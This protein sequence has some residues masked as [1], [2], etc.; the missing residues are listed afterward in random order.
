MPIRNRSLSVPG[1]SGTHTWNGTTTSKSSHGL[2][3]T[4]QDTVGNPLGE[5]PL[6]A[7]KTETIGGAINGRYHYLVP[8]VYDNY[9]AAVVQSYG[10]SHLTVPNKFIPAATALAA[11]HPGEPMVDIPVF[12]LELKDLPSMYKHAFRRAKSLANAAKS[13]DLASVK[14]YLKDPRNPAEDWLN[15]HFGWAPLLSDL[16]ALASLGSDMQKRALMFKNASNNR[17]TRRNKLGTQT[18]ISVNNQVA[19]DTSMASWY[20]SN[21]KETTVEKWM[22]SHWQLDPLYLKHSLFSQHTQ[23][24]R[25][26]LGLSPSLSQAWELMPWSWFIDWFSEIGSVIKVRSNRGGVTF[27]NASIMEHSYTKE[28]VIPRKPPFSGIS[29]SPATLV[30]ETKRRTPYAPS[31]TSGFVNIYSPEQLATLSA[32]SILRV[33]R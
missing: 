12:L 4:M 7:H 1:Y 17:I 29:G 9:P 10:G 14:R 16:G 27:H 25:A 26:S 8:G 33:R 31:V 30:Y 19:Y 6:V 21:T 2:K 22:V 23:L 24:L 15:Y 13:D 20:G 32:L 28:S 18:A 11:A 3:K 5:N